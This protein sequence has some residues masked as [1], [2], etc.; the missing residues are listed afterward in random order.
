MTIFERHN[1]ANNNNPK[2]NIF[3]LFM[4]VVR[5]CEVSVTRTTI[6]SR[7]Q[8]KMCGAGADIAGGGKGKHVGNVQNR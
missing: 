5:V 8:N 4:S 1:N 6:P 3:P 2:Q 7:E